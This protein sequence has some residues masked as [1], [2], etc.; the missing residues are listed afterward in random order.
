[1]FKKVLIANRGVVAVRV[2]RTL[3]KMGIAWVAV[4]SDADKDLPYVQEADEAYAIGPAPARESYLKV[5]KLI[6]V[7]KESGCDSV[8]P[9]YGFLSEDPGFA[10]KVTQAGATFIGPS[11]KHIEAMGHKVR[12]REHMNNAGIPVLPASLAIPEGQIDYADHL[13]NIRLPML[14]KAAAGG[15]GIGMQRVYDEKSLIGAIEKTRQLSARAFG[16]GTVYLERYIEEPRHIEFQMVGDQ[17][18]NVRNVFERDCSI[19]RRHQKVVE[20]SPAPALDRNKC[21]E[22]AGLLVAA[23]KNW[24]YDSLGTVEMLLDRDGNYYFLETNTRLQV[25]HGVTEAVTGLDLVEVQIRIAAGESLDQI[26]PDTVEQTGHAVEMRIYAEDPVRFFPSVGTLSRFDVPN[27]E[28][29]RTETHLVA[30]AAVTP[31][32]DPMLALVIAKG[33][34]RTEALQRAQAAL[35]GF[36]IEGVKTNIPFLSRLLGSEVFREVRHHTTLAEEFSKSV[37]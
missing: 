25:E 6:E 19:Q 8:H 5:D 17:H 28:G 32:Y 7:I 9:G 13:K 37:A 1:M 26:L 18:G 23:L 22:M 10:E 14:V 11:P 3:R 12:A 21:R 2:A 35:D 20:E 33:A 4:Y 29:V 34:D 36:A 31:N 15:G 16:D 24:K 30:G 27:V